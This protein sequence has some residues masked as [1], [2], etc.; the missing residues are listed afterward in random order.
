[1]AF[2]KA[3]ATLSD[4]LHE[5]LTFFSAQQYHSFPSSDEGCIALLLDLFRAHKCMLVL[6]NVETVLQVGQ[7]DG[8]YRADY[9]GYELFIGQL[10][11]G[12]HQSCVLLTSR[13]KLKIIGPLESPSA[14]VR[15]LKVTGLNQQESQELLR[16]R[17]LL[18]DEHAWATLVYSYV[19]NPLALK[20]VSEIIRDLFGGDIAHFLQQ[21]EI[22]FN[23]ITLS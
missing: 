18:G 4:L 22:Y 5:C 9:E 20:M 6:D 8:R 17:T 19:G 11:E 12:H 14:P 21:G 13:E 15:S 7:S 23:D 3:C 1:M 2:L 16:E 10:A